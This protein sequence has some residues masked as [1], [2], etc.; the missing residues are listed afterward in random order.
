MFVSR[1]ELLLGET[2]LANLAL[3]RRMM[4]WWAIRD[5]KHS[6][7]FIVIRRRSSKRNKPVQPWT[8]EHFWLLLLNGLEVNMADDVYVI[9]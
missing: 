6:L 2:S 5:Y 4:R 7:L 1:L 9:R 3:F 8:I